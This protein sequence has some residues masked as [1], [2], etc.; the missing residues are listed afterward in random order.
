MTGAV[1]VAVEAGTDATRLVVP[2]PDGRPEPVAVLP[3]GTSVSAALDELVGSAAGPVVLVHPP[4]RPAGLVLVGRTVRPV[5][6]PV[7]LLGGET[8]VRL[9]VDAGRSGT[10]LTIVDDG[11][12]RSTERLDL[13]G[14]RLD[15]V[16]AAATGCP[17]TSARAVRE[18]L[19]TADRLD[20]PGVGAV[21][22]AD[23]ER[24][25][26]PE[27]DEMVARVSAL[28]GSTRVDEVVVAG[29]LART[30]LLAALLD[31][32]CG[33]PVR[34]L[35]EPDLAAVRGALGW[36]AAGADTA[37]EPEPGRSAR[38]RDRGGAD[39]AARSRRSIVLPAVA[40]VGVLLV[41]AGTVLGRAPATADP[42]DRTL[43]QYGYSL[44][45]PA[46]WEHTGGEPE[47]RRTLLTRTGSAAGVELVSVE[48]SPLG[49]DSATEPDRAR[50]ELAVAHRGVAGVGDLR[51]DT[52]A[53]R[54][55]TRYRQQAG[56][57][58]VVDWYVLFDGTDELVVGCR[59]PA[60][61]PAPEA[62]R[63]CAEVV[64]SVRAVDR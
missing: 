30:P 8:G 36:A 63:A 59:G 3:A 10:E 37:I 6:A 43:V 9:V 1:V 64:G 35:D 23:V 44:A 24:L 52:V 7:A 41:G 26:R 28:A 33:C 62:G 14:D 13:G 11:C 19:S 47:R 22:A 53:G 38:G 61:G 45:L 60:R 48:R 46:G 51:P 18:A 21:G 32:R 55:V 58:A 39:D 15:R 2:G 31:E 49:Y 27:F 12:V 40:V 56:P 16:L 57:D 50:D 25:L 5:A 54:A 42:P 29:G 34:V 20:V 4:G 17:P